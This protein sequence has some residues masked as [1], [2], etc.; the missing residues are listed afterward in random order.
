MSDM[1]QNFEL[2]DTDILDACQELPISRR[3]LLLP[4]IRKRVDYTL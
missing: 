4:H 1:Y 3:N 2:Y